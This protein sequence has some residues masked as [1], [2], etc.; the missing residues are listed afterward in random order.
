MHWCQFS[1]VLLLVAVSVSFG[2]RINHSKGACQKKIFDACLKSRCHCSMKHYYRQ[3]APLDQKITWSMLE[4]ECNSIENLRAFVAMEKCMLYEPDHGSEEYGETEEPVSYP[5]EVNEIIQ[6][7]LNAKLGII[8]A[9]S[10]IQRRSFAEFVL[11]ISDDSAKEVRAECEDT[12]AL[13][14]INTGGRKDLDW[15]TRLEVTGRKIKSFGTGEDPV[16]H[17]FPNLRVLTLSPHRRT[18]T[19]ALTELSFLSHFYVNAQKSLVKLYCAY[20]GDKCLTNP[21]GLKH[22]EL[23]FDEQRGG[24]KSG[25]ELYGK[26]RLPKVC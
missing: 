22:L 16:L 9:E 7:K 24:R 17:L 3:N 18:F 13:R 5:I 1:N 23:R 10:D 6:E 11:K 2:D 12:P 8:D 14:C 4:M 20:R 26:L 21:E 19:I 25:F 15:V